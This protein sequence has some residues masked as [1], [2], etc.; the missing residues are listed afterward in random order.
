[1]GWISA[2]SSIPRRLGRDGRLVSLDDVV[3]TECNNQI[4]RDDNWRLFE[5]G[6]DVNFAV[7][8]NE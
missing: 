8:M 3:V 4:A 5:A 1:M 6:F 2:P 7:D